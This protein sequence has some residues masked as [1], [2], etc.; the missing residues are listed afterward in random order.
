MIRACWILAVILL[1][2]DVAISGWGWAILPDRVPTHWNIHNEVDGYGSKFITVLL[3]PLVVLATL[4]LFAALPALSPKGF[5]VD[6]FRP[7]TAVVMVIVVGLLSY[8]HAVILY[9][10]WNSATGGP[11]IDLG[12]FLLGGM[13]AFFALMGNS[14]G[15]VH[16]NF[17]IGVR[18]PWTLAS[19]RVWNDV[20][21]LAAWIW[22]G[23]G[24]LGVV[25]LVM[26]ANLL[27]LAGLFTAA[28]LVP[29]VYSY[30]HYKTL[31][32]RGAL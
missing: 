11:A 22:T 12:R 14:L 18:L 6:S 13:F 5:E 10:T 27:V 21:R 31:E 3:T 9:A 15:K 28:V 16:K 2:G 20:H 8:T 24:A 29:C 7:T 32:R 17:Y 1:V 19:D 30:V 4:G 26:G 23:A 25:L